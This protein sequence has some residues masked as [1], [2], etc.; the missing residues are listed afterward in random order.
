MAKGDDTQERLIRLAV[1]LI[2][3]CDQLPDTRTDGHIASQLLRS[4]TSPAA[5]Y[6]EA[7]GQKA[8]RTSFISS[9]SSSKSS[10]NALF[11]W[12]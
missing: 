11:G 7:E 4:G 2:R 1:A 12:P 5:K 8:T 10:T 3:V 6:A 9:R